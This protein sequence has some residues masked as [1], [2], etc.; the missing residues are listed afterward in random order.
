MLTA[1]GVYDRA[2][3]LLGVGFVLKVL[4]EEAVAVED[5][6][7]TKKIAKEGSAPQAPMLCSTAACS[8]CLRDLGKSL[9]APL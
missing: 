7:I 1:S 2:V 4:E 6:P 5:H 3:R 8:R 9:Y